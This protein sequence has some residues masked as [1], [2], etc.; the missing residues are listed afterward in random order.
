MKRTILAGALLFAATA[1]MAGAATKFTY[2]DLV[3]KLTDLQGLAVLPPPGEK[4]AQCSSYDRSSR[5]DAATGKYIDWDA[6]GDNHGIIRMEGDTEVLAEMTGPGVIWRIWS[7]APRAGHVK[8]YIDGAA[9]PTVDL[10]FQ[11]YFDLANPPFIY[12]SIVHDASSGK[13]SY[14]PIPFQKS[15]KVVGDKGWGDYYHF[16]YTTYPKGTIVPTFKRDLGTE[17]ASALQKADAFLTNELGTDPVGKRKGEA[18][19]DRSVVVPSHGTVVAA[20][21]SGKQ[22]ITALQITLSP[23]ALGDPARTLREVVLRITWDGDKEPG[24]WAPLGDFFG[25][26]P[27]INYYKSLPL[28]MIENA[29]DGTATFYSFWYMPFS[30]GAKIELVNDGG[31]SFPLQ[32]HITHA[33]L[34]RPISQ[35]GR[36]HAK[37]HRDAFL[38]TIPERMIDWPMLRAEG[39]GRYCGVT[40]HVWNPRGGWWGEGDEKFFVDGEKFPSTFGTGSEDYF[41]YAWGNPGLFQK[42]YHDQT[43]CDPAGNTSLNRWQITDNGPFQDSIEASI[44][45]Y[46]S[47]DRPCQY[48]A[49]AYFYLAAGQADPYK[50][51]EPLAERTDYR[52]QIK[53]N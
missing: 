4:C 46:W 8:I 40:L 42:V 26:A 2:I 35:L 12:P 44:E 34:S 36:F 10:P 22:A 45:K 49:V 43:V 41:G 28:G 13:N 38:N 32:F 27:G 24:V 16:T 23:N 31:Q 37:W 6:N 30:K 7:A 52:T 39:R 19:D 17:E 25:T 53:P 20:T 9:Q 3:K 21:L 47:N 1:G 18:V 14:L 29:S 33:P 11:G 50:P 5:Y 15:C 48:A 51:V